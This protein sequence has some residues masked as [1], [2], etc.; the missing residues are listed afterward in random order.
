MRKDQWKTI[1]RQMHLVNLFRTLFFHYPVRMVPTNVTR[2]PVQI[3][4]RVKKKR[5]HHQWSTNRKVRMRRGITIFGAML[6][7]LKS[8]V[9]KTRETI[10]VS[11]VTTTKAMIM[12]EMKNAESK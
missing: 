4:R 5:V 3:Y 6:N 11:M 9:L 2:T 12:M 1:I 10:L 8:E 7:A